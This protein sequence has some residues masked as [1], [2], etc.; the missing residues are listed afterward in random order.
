MKEQIR[1]WALPDDILKEVYLHFTEV[2]PQDPENNLIRQT[3]P[4]DG[5]VAE[6]IRRDAHMKNCE[7]EFAF[8]VVFGHD[9]ETLIVERGNYKYVKGDD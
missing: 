1:S 9:E 2:L 3:T 7:H 5:M 6:F 4:F 8:L